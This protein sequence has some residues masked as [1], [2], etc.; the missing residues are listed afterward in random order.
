MIIN[1]LSEMKKFANK[2][3]SGLREGDVLN[4]IGEMSAGKTTL[5]G[6]ISQYFSIENSSSP[7]FAIVNIYEGDIKIYHLDLYRFDDQDEILDIDYET[8]FYPDGGLT[9]LE[10]AENVSDYLPDDMINIEIRK[11]S[12]NKREIE[13]YED[14]ER[15]KEINE[16][17]GN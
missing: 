13:I 17:L 11:I 2:L 1:G 3:A 8:Y 4:L 6:F 10:W 5:T 14:S 9:I 7:T 16:Y 15:G 12:G